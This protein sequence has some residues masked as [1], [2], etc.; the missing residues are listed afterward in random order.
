MFFF[1]AGVLCGVFVI[2]DQVKP[3]ARGT[4]FALRRMGLRVCM[5]TGDNRRTAQAIAQ[6]ASLFFS[7]CSMFLCKRTASM[8]GDIHTKQ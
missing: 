3:E 2:A 4:V 6:Q 8:C 5:L 7:L 1:L